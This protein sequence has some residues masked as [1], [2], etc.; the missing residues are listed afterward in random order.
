MS[1]VADTTAAAPAAVELT[2]Q[3]QAT[4]AVAQ[5]G[6]QEPVG[7]NEIKD[8]SGRPDHI[9]EKFWKDG[10]LD[11]DALARSYSELE[12]KQ[13][14]PAAAAP[15]ADEAAAADA[16]AAAATPSGKI[17]KPKTEEAPAANPLSD[18]LTAARTDFETTQGF[19]EETAAA[20]VAAGIP[21]EIQAIYVAGLEALTTQN[22][23]T[24][25]GFVDGADNYN[26][27]SQWAGQTLT[28]AELDK[29]NE[30][31]DDPA[32]R[33]NAVRG[34]YARYAAARPS[35]GNLI[36]PAGTPS[37]AGD[38]YSSRDDLLSEQRNP[39]YQTDP[40]F[41]QAVAEKLQRSQAAGF[42]LVKRSMFERDISTR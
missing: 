17:E 39:L 28:D 32:S 5:A 27:M 7:V 14:A 19:S 20:L 15:A 26:A 11:A 4:I 40:K 21:A 29:Y 23:T 16:A 6:I 1:E 37:A 36:T 9:P 31:L 13:S 41:R 25:H 35:E 33:E 22:L 3:E 10:K 8:T 12:K 42:Q 34:L 38:V 2:P 24:I 18:L 30:A